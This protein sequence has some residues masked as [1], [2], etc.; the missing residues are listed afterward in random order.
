MITKHNTTTGY[1]WKMAMGIGLVGVTAVLVAAMALAGRAGTPVTAASLPL[2]ASI[3]TLAANL[4]GTFGFSKS[5]TPMQSTQLGIDLPRSADVRTLPRGLADYIRPNS[6]APAVQN[7]PA[8][9]GID[10]PRGADVRTLPRG[11]SDYIRH[12]N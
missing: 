3:R 7:H 4:A 10:L 5:V 8:Q 6:S 2:P 9:L 11:L 12:A 1:G